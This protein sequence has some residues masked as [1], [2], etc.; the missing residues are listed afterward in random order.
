MSRAEREFQLVMTTAGS[1]EQA[2]TLAKELVER[3]LAA[4]VTIVG[5][6]CSIYRWQGKIEEEDEKLLLI[7]TE[8]RQFEP[9]RSAIRELHSYEVP[10]VLALPIDAGDADYLAWLSAC[11]DKD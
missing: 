4:C 5:A 3:R 6:A 8:R 1:E 7:K 2:R 9:L 11:L 10:E